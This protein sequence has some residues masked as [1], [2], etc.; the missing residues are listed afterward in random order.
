MCPE[1]VYI[2]LYV[3]KLSGTL[4]YQFSRRSHICGIPCLP[5]RGDLGARAV[6]N[7]VRLRTAV[8]GTLATAMLRHQS[9]PNSYPNLQEL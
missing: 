5:S 6:H 8:T 1:F 2:I 7:E 3:L 9:K 4:K